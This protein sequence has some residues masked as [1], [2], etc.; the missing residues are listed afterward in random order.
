[1]KVLAFLVAVLSDGVH[2]AWEKVDGDGSI[3]AYADR[4]T[5]RQTGQLVRMWSLLDFST[6]R[7][8]ENRPAY[9]SAKA[10]IEYDCAEERT[11][12][13]YLVNYPER[14]GWGAAVNRTNVGGE[15]SPVMPDSFE[16]SLWNIACRYTDNTVSKR[17]VP[18]AATRET[19]DLIARIAG[20]KSIEDIPQVQMSSRGIPSTGSDTTTMEPDAQDTTGLREI[21]HAAEKAAA[22]AAGM[23]HYTAT[24]VQAANAVRDNSPTQ[25]APTVKPVPPPVPAKTTTPVSADASNMAGVEDSAVKGVLKGIGALAFFLLVR[26]IYGLFSGAKAKGA[27]K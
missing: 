6:P 8:I 21:Q 13:L 18:G 11:R 3:T 12:L 27:G 25:P 26:W 4:S 23:D 1:M 16:R 7:I 19:D 10:Q 14:M 5:I 17:V 22:P 20:V 2:A 24:D 15:W 9:S